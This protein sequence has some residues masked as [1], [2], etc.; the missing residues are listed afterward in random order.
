LADAGAFFLVLPLAGLWR[1]VS[2]AL[3]SLATSGDVLVRL[4][5]ACVAAAQQQGRRHR[6]QQAEQ[7]GQ[8][9]AREAHGVAAIWRA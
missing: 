1:L 8:L 3:S 9:S 5:P 6:Q 4:R 7:A 2:P